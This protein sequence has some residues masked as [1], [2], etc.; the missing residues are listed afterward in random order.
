VLDQDG[1]ILRANPAFLDLVQVGGEGAVLG[2][3]LGR[4]L[5]RPGAA[6]AVLLTTLQR[7]RTVRLM[8][9]AVQ[10]EQ[11]NETA[12]EIS[13]ASDSEADP[14]HIGVMLRDVSRRSSGAP[15]AGSVS[16]PAVPQAPALQAVL[17]AMVGQIGQTPLPRLMRETVELLERHYI[18]EALER[19]DG[20]RTATAELLGLSRQSLYVK[21]NRYGL[22]GESQA[23][24]DTSTRDLTA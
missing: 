6:L 11:G 9:T 19:A 23:A 3:S 10:G 21:L 15:S 1:V 20:N 16:G 13:A 17:G 5:Q 14:R 8:V 2:Q 4:W 7:H 12:V 18:E 22:D 24:H